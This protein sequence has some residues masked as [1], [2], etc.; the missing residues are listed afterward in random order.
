MAFV[1]STVVSTGWRWR[2]RATG[3]DGK[4][5]SCMGARPNGEGPWDARLRH[6]RKCS[7][8]VGSLLL[9]AW[10]AQRVLSGAILWPLP[11]SFHPLADAPVL[12]SSSSSSSSSP[13]AALALTAEQRLVDEAWRLVN[14]AYADP[15]FEPAKWYRK[16]VQYL[17]RAYVDREQAHAAIREMVASLGDPYTRFLTPAQ[18]QSAEAVARGEL[19][20]IGLELYPTRAIPAADVPGAGRL[21]LTP[22]EDSGGGGGGGGGIYVAGVTDGAPAARAG[23]RTLDEIL[24]V[25]GVE[26]A[27]LTP[28]DAAARI[29]GPAGTSV[30]LLVRHRGADAPELVSAVRQALRLRSVEAPNERLDDAAYVR[31]KQFQAGTADDLRRTVEEVRRAHPGATRLVID[32]R[33]NTGGSF[34]GGVDAARLFLHR[35]DV[36]VYVSNRHDVQDEVRATTDGPYADHASLPVVL[37]V[38]HATASSSE[39]FSAALHD[40]HRAA[41]VGERSFGKGVVQTVQ[42]LSDGS[43]LAIT[44]SHYETPAHQDIHHKGIE[45][46]YTAA[47]PRDDEAATDRWLRIQD[48][49]V[50]PEAW[51]ASA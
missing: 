5:W 6:W 29:R 35:G 31:I 34:N 38:N 4:A 16:R 32:L 18:L 22:S 1:S 23:I 10:L 20:G 8:S 36:V 41:I 13:P 12:T 9:G 25:D 33:D 17:K 11:F 14:D 7:S 39:I 46:D 44:I 51:R 40:H 15:T 30:Q 19:V 37:L 43:G 28:D 27:G 3:R 45:P 42:R 47:C 26:L 50:P 21:P 24:Q 49:C 48:V 2:S